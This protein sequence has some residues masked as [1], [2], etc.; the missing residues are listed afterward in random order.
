MTSVHVIILTVVFF[1][2]LSLHAW[3]GLRDVVID[4]I[5]HLGYRIAILSIVVILIFGQLLWLAIV[6]LRPINE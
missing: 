6:L 5:H 4:Y 2:A 1:T 3:I